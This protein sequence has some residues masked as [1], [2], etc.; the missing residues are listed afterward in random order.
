MCYTGSCYF[1]D[2]FGEC[3]KPRRELCPME[4]GEG[5]DPD[6]DSRDFLC[7]TL[8]EQRRDDALLEAQCSCS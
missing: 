1:E 2:A 4:H 5:F 3:R 7:D 6:D 8:Y